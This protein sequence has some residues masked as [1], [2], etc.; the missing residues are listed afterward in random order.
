MI[1]WEGT[2]LVSWSWSGALVGICSALA[3]DSVDVPGVAADMGFFVIAVLAKHSSQYRL[4]AV[5]FIQPEGKGESS[6]K[7][8]P[9]IQ[10]I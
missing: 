8:G 7:S 1:F 6:S 10:G 2:F 3:V 5:G 9:K 4:P